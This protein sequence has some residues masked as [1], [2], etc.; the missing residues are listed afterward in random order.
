MSKAFLEI[1]E[2]PD[3]SIILRRS[4][5]EEAMVTLTFSKEARGFLRERYIDVAKSMFHAGLQTAGEV[6][7][8]MSPEDEQE[9]ASQQTIH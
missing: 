8:E 1:V 7:D 4:E 2:L 3:G 5:E 6:L 9:E